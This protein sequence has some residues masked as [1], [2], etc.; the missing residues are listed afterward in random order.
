MLIAARRMLERDRAGLERR[1]HSRTRARVGH[2]RPRPRNSDI[3]PSDIFPTGRE[4]GDHI[5]RRSYTLTQLVR[6]A[7]VCERC[8]ISLDLPAPTNR[9]IDNTIGST[10]AFGNPHS[11]VAWDA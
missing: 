6:A 2:R 7:E 11:H 1:R 3:F 5:E 10:R 9:T 8:R 4:R